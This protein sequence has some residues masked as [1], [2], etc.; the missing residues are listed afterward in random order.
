MMKLSFINCR[1]SLIIIININ[2]NNKD[3]NNNKKQVLFINRNILRDS[4]INLKNTQET[5]KNYVKVFNN[6]HLVSSER[7]KLN[8]RGINIDIELN[9]EENKEQI[10]YKNKATTKKID[11]TESLNQQLN[12]IT[13]NIINKN[14]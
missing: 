9:N 8:N 2:I 7:N 3:E 1:N 14:H 5:E 13:V 4:T 6:K 10:I 11:N 12:Q